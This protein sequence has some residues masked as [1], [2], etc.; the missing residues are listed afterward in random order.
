MDFEDKF[1]F[2]LA[3]NTIDHIYDTLGV[4]KKVNVDLKEGGYFYVECPNDNQALKTMLPEKQRLM[5][6]KFMYQRAHYYSF[7]F[8]TLK[9]LLTEQGFETVDEQ[10]RHDYT[11][12]NYLQWFFSGVP[13]K[14]LQTA[15]ENPGLH[16]GNSLFE[17]EM[18]VVFERANEEFK[19]IINKHKL[20]ESLCILARKI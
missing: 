12:V 15:K 3:L 7:T 20:G 4:V 11:L 17:L 13:M 9:R 8:D 19:E 10:S 6:Q 5:F 1:D 2:I 14:K 16:E 18:N